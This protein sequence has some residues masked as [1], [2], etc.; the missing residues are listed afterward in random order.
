[1][2]TNTRSLPVA[3]AVRETQR[4]AAAV[5]RAR[6]ALDAPVEIVSRGDST[7]RGH[8]MA[9]LAVLDGARRRDTGHGFDAVVVVPAYPEAGR[10]T[11]DDVHYAT[12]AGRPV[13]VGRSEFSKD[14]TFGY[15]A[16]DLRDYLVE[17]S[18]GALARDDILSLSLQQIR[19]GGPDAVRRT[20][21]G[22][23]DGRFVVVNAVEGSD[24]DVV[25]LAMAQ[26][27][28]EGM[29]FGCRCAPSFVPALVG[30]AHRGVIEADELA[31]PP[32][33]SAHGLVVVGSHVGLTTRQVEVAQRR[34]GLEE[35]E[36]DVARVTSTSGAE[37]YLAS[38]VDDVRAGLAASDVLLFTSRTLRRVE[39]ADE[40]LALSRSVSQAVSA[41]VRGALSARPAW[42]VAKGGITSHDVAALGLGMRRGRVLGQLLPG[43]ISVFSPTEAHP[44]AIGMPYV[45]FAGNVGDE[46]TLAEVIDVLTGRRAHVT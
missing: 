42:V 26:L 19:E 2:L 30:L 25:A 38:V 46:D 8:V 40:S 33:R 28:A 44:D 36:L 17:K 32:A 34:G 3:E 15:A 6:H 4:A 16:S 20:L 7:L 22:A 31:T 10:F 13:P 23:V 12:V 14:A 5:D 39:D 27:G 11:V 1:M 41:I 21:S 29:A 43:I 9:E 35:V 37:A 18:D 45:V 24:L